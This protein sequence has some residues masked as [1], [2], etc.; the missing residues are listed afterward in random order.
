MRITKFVHSCLL[1]EQDDRIGIIDPGVFSWESGL[2]DSTRLTRLDEIMITH[3][4]PDHM[5]LPFINSLLLQ[6]PKAQIV[7][8]PRAAAIL[9]EAG[10]KNI[11]TQSTETA[12]LF[13]APHE[14][15]APLSPTPANS[16][17]HYLGRLS[18]PGDSHHFN[19]TREILALPVTAP[20]GTLPRAAE[21]GQELLPKYIIPIHDWHWNESARLQTYD[22]LEAFFAKAGVTFIKVKDGEPVNL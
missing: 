15:L 14:P 1:V 16:G 17:V 7:T 18:H 13:D 20:W 3:E 22:R 6:F 9:R 8:N 5:H 19:E 12:Q 4:H 11:I 2:F 10:I 21:L